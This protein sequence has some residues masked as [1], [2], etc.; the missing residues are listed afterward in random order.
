VLVG[1]AGVQRDELPVAELQRHGHHREGAEVDPQRM[2]RLAAQ[3]RELVEQAG[4]RPDPVVLDARAQLRQPDPIGV[5]ILDERQAQRGAERRGGGEAGA[6]REVAVD[7]ESARTQDVPR[8][9]QPGDGAAH[10]RPPAFGAWRRRERERIP[11][12]KVVG[13]GLD[14]VSG[15]EWHGRDRHTAVDRERE[16]EA[17]VVVRVL[18]D[19]VHAA[20]AV[21][22]DALLSHA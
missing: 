15:Q 2:P 5:L 16:R 4:L 14:L 6:V 9:L 3:H 12:A 17:V 10:E 1:G 8:G 21:R 19:Q 13:N 22:D 7:D 11:L 20:G 18:A